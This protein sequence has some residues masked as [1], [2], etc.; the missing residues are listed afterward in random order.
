MI[1]AGS[2]VRSIYLGLN[3]LDKEIVLEHYVYESELTKSPWK[4]FL[5]CHP[6]LF[7]QKSRN[8]LQFYMYACYY[9]MIEFRLIDIY[10]LNSTRLYNNRTLLITR[11]LVVSNRF[12]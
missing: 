7:S 4:I 5:F 1:L 9:I 8:L 2:G 3:T 12:Y 10:S 11:D 6:F